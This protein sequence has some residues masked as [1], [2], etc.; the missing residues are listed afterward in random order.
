MT[1]KGFDT[2]NLIKSKGFSVLTATAFIIGEVAGGG[3]LSLPQATAQA[4]WAGLVMIVYCATCA[5]IS[6][7][8]LAKSWIVL[9]ERYPEYR[10]GLTR[11]PFSTIGYHA[12]GKWMRYVFY[13][14]LFV[15]VILHQM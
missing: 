15:S 8:C 5:G 1:E 6:G 3:I 4:G 14:N 12:Y 10:E 11:K 2:S 7:M 9:E 13:N